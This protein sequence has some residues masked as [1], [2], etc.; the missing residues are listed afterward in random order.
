MSDR[1]KPFLATEML[2]QSTVYI[3][4][5]RACFASIFRR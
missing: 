1:P 3:N 5:L 2:G 4:H